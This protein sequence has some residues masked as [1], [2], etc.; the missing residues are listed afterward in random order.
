MKLALWALLVLAVLVLGYLGVGLVVAARLSA[1]S[2]QPQELTPT[3]VG[4]YY[5]EVHIQS[6]DG[7]ELAGWWVPGED[8]SR[9]V[10]LVPG[11]GGD[12]SDRHV[13][14]SASVYAMRTEVAVRVG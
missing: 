9:A 13:I 4:L 12:K 6:T 10:V 7:L 14:K 2:H 3:D 11:I 5:R 8:P 1:P